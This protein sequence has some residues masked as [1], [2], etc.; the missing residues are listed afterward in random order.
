M[1]EKAAIDQLIAEGFVKSD[2]PMWPELHPDALYGLV[3]EIVG[4]LLPHTEADPAALALTTLAQFGCAADKNRYAVVGAA[5]HPARINVVLVGRTSSARKGTAQ[6]ESARV[7]EVADP[8][9]AQERVAGGL[10]SG[11]GLV[12]AVRDGADEDDPGVFDKRLYVHEPEFSRV[13]AVAKRE[14]SNLSQILREAWDGKRIQNMTRNNPLKATGAHV[15]VVGH[16]TTEEL[17]RS[18]T[19]TEK[20]SGFANRFLFALVRRSKK[21]P[22]GGHLEQAAIDALG[23][24]MRAALQ[25]ARLGRVMHRSP[26]AEELWTE[27][28]MAIDDDADGMFGAMVNR[29]PAQM[30]RLSVAYALLDGA[31]TIETEHVRAA[32]AIWDYCE[33][34]VKW[35][36]GDVVGDPVADKLLDALRKA[37]PQGLDR[38]DQYR[39]F[40]GHITHSRLE[41]ALWSLESQGLAKT[42]SETT[43]GRPRDLTYALPSE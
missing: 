30:L 11:E 12:Y 17:R 15:C 8:H 38:D 36:F 6:S 13:L 41:A 39:V 20:A 21:L 28:Y 29:G 4:T 2:P 23:S 9:F 35:I 14:G 3:G 42:S 32:K 37:A 31:A 34:S 5:R 33:A 43:G 7:I 22:S 25:E 18:L 1:V 19:D 24:K 40:S 26:D 27:I 16:I 10:S